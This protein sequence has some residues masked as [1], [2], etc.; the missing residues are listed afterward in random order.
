[1][2]SVSTPNIT[3][4]VSP[5]FTFDDD[6]SAISA[7]T[8]E[9]MMMTVPHPDQKHL[10]SDTIQNGD[11]LLP[12][13]METDLTVDFPI[14]KEVTPPALKY[15]VQLSKDAFCRASTIPRAN[16]ANQERE[17]VERINSL[18]STSTIRTKQRIWSY[19][20]TGRSN[21][22]SPTGFQYNTP[23]SSRSMASNTSNQQ[24]QQQQQLQQRFNA[25]FSPCTSGNSN[26]SFD[27]WR[28]VEQEFWD[29]VVANDD[30]NDDVN[31]RGIS[32]AKPKKSKSLSSNRQ[33]SR[34][35]RSRIRSFDG[36]SEPS[37]FSRSRDATTGTAITADVSIFSSSMTAISR[38]GS[39]HGTLPP[40]RSQ[41]WLALHPHNHPHDPF[42]VIFASTAIPDNDG[43]FLDHRTSTSAFPFDTVDSGEI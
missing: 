28:T 2:R 8:L 31:D 30:D 1:M 11:V 20:S 13:K 23:S 43:F 33:S 14:E 34:R 42:P 25:S 18:S 41:S 10:N 19:N 21:I 3:T 37:T 4:I 9:A 12:P 39:S 22:K 29:S 5:N 6:I 26:Q 24:Q 7:N 40:Q 17:D 27:R 15:S 32:S 16:Q 38:S 36:W 35:S